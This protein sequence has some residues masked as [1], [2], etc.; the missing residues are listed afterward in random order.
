MANLRIGTVRYAEGLWR[1]RRHK[2]VIAH[3][4]DSEDF[5]TELT[6]GILP[7]VSVFL[8]IVNTDVGIGILKI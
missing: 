4:T 7:Q 3:C 5:P 8:G 6:F 1:M 2:P